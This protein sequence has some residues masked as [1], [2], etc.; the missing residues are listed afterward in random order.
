MRP[1]AA[2]VT[3]R[4]IAFVFIAVRLGCVAAHDRHAVREHLFLHGSAI[5]NLL[6]D[7]DRHLILSLRLLSDEDGDLLVLESADLRGRRIVSDE[8]DAPNGSGLMQTRDGA[9]RALIVRRENA[10]T[11]L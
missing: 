4:T 6:G 5:E 11:G 3:Q 2:S 10:R 1:D 8:L 9:N 7:L